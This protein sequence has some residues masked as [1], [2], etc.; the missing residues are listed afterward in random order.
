MV[1]IPVELQQALE[2]DNVVFFCGAGVSRSAG[3]PTFK[4]LAEW[5]LTSLLP[6]R[7][8]CRD[9]STEALAWK[10]FGRGRYDEA[11]GIL[12][13]AGEGG[14]EPRKVREKVRERL[15]RR[16]T[17]LANHETLVSLT[18]LEKDN[19][20]LVTTNFDLL[21]EKAYMKHRRREKSKHKLPIQFAPV[22]PPAKPSTFKGLV[23]LHGRLESWPDENQLVLTTADFGTAYMLE[24][25]AL[26][27][28]VELFR[29]FH[30]VFIGYSLEDPTMRYLVSALAAAR[31]GN[32]DQFK[33]P[34]AFASYDGEEGNAGR[35][36]A[37][38]EWKLSGITAVPFDKS[39]KYSALWDALKAWDED[40]R[41]GISGR[42]QKVARLGQTPPAPGEDSSEV[43]ELA[44]ALKDQKVAR[45]FA[46][47]EG[48][49]CPKSSW[50]PHLEKEGLFGL[51]TVRTEDWND[52]GGS[53]VSLALDDNLRLHPSTK[54]LGRWISRQLGSQE[55]IDWV[56]RRGAVLHIEFRQQVQ[57][58]L[59]NEEGVAM[60]PAARKLWRV[61]ADLGYAHALS[62]KHGNNQFV[63]FFEPSLAT[64][65]LFSTRSFLDRLRPIPIF[66]VR[67]DYVQRDGDKDGERPGDWYETDVE[68]VGIRGDYE[69]EQLRR[70]SEDWN[71]ALAG[72]AEDLTT[73][74]SEA[75]VWFQEF[76]LAN[77]EIDKTHFEYR[78][79]SPHEQNE[80][81]PTW[82]QLIELVRDARDAL[83][84]RRENEAAFR[85]ERRWQSL[86]YPVFQRLALYAATEPSTGNVEFGVEI[87]LNGPRPALWNI[88]VLRETLRFLRKRGADLRPNDL[89]RLTDSIL[90]GPPRE[91]YPTDL[92][93]EQWEKRRDFQ[94]LLRLYKL[95]ESGVTLPQNAEDAYQRIQG[96]DPWEPRGDRS[97]EF[98]V[99][100]RSGPAADRLD[101]QVVL[102]D[103]GA[104]STEEFV[105]W[106]RAQTG[107]GISPWESGGGWLRFVRNDLLT[108]VG[109]LRTAS[110]QGVWAI[111]PWYDVLLAVEQKE[112]E[113]E[114][115]SL[116]GEVP[117]N[118][119]SSLA[120]PAARWLEKSWKQLGEG[121]RRTVWRRIWDASQESDEPDDGWD[122]DAAINH[123]AGVLGGVLY[124]EL[125]EHIPEVRPG[126]N[127][128]FPIA[129]RQDFERL[130]VCDDSSAKLARVRMAPMLFALYRIDPDWTRRTYFSRMDPENQESFDPYLWDAFFFRAR[131]SEDLLRAFKDLILGVIVRRQ[132]IPNRVHDN[133]I[134][135]FVHMA[136]PPGRGIE[137]QDARNVLWQLGPD[138]LAYAAM[139][140]RDI[141]QGAGDRSP[142]LWKETV[143]P[144][145]RAAW[146]T[147]PVD[148]SPRLSKHLAWMALEAGEAFPEIVVELSELIEGDEHSFVLYELRLKEQKSGFV[149]EYPDACLM[150]IG[151]VVHDGSNHGLVQ[152]LLEVVANANPELAQSELFRAL[153]E[154]FS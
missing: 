147:R 59:K 138:A 93:Q 82:T 102:E 79:I 154:R 115:A 133:A 97:E 12:E 40:H 48:D 87:L 105:D 81:A 49:R 51:P 100:M 60:A 61:L 131:C 106:A 1:L 72:M 50:I 84:R 4:G 16:P 37:V 8:M 134:S 13:K 68:L 141:L 52:I 148:R 22:L 124:A 20:R 95:I 18:E 120:S 62:E 36:R 53:L 33:S 113:A 99:F 139:A 58:T 11:L 91:K 128:G 142:A 75:M 137:T 30:V 129:L 35:N 89:I 42:R 64:D 56:L 88:Y 150:L 43:R 14:Y 127:E 55:A 103:F 34:F 47:L 122:L 98:V 54:Q 136:I 143:K 104:M 17:T 90:E 31:E 67:P 101:D 24:G 130:V 151:K 119:L 107:D 3:L 45:Y 9:G 77:S 118:V 74:L 145:F 86:P 15:S 27:F 153:S 152:E 83:R 29:H 117:S 140:L 109:L 78:S 126:Q 41:Q 135:L 10:A 116:L 25:W 76:G 26:R 112:Q 123:A 96:D 46:E 149:S 7:D 6:P 94:I 69:I 57:L 132:L 21:L 70:R 114:I 5:V 80:H 44:W 85:L 111:P 121:E 110:D 32:R 73:R 125:T 108:A 146:P 144:W 38:H 39:E 2:E 19:G 23:Y 71:G 28:V 92:S 63:D 66:N 65:E